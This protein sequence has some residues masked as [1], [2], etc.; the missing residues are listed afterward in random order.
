V[1]FASLNAVVEGVPQDRL[2]GVP[3]IGAAQ[4]AQNTKA[5]HILALPTVIQKAVL[6]SQPGIPDRMWNKF[7]VLVLVQVVAGI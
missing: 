3:H 1:C 2:F 5:A 6:A 4:L 7:L